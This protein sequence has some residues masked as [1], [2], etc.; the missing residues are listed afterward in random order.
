MWYRSS[1]EDM[2]AMYYIMLPCL[3]YYLGGIILLPLIAPNWFRDW[4]I[5]WF[6]V[7]IFI[8]PIASEIIAFILRKQSK[9][10]GKKF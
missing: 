10:L 7:G 8:F 9:N 4:F 1:R 6:L 5:A 3:I 2:G